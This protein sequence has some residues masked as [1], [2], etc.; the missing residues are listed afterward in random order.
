MKFNTI[1]AGLALTAAICAARADILY[2]QFSV[3][4]Q[5]TFAKQYMNAKSQ[6]GSE[7]LY[8]YLFANGTRSTGTELAAGEG[9]S[10]S[11]GDSPLDY[12]L[13]SDVASA[14][15]YWELVGGTGDAATTYLKSE[16]KSYGDLLDYISSNPTAGQFGV[17]NAGTLSYTLL[18]EPTSGLLLLLGVA[19]LALRRR[20]I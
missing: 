17:F 7:N 6:A 20:R 13:G 9:D 3:D 8:L 16:T 11:S 15:F 4:G 12:V 18:P 10:L 19:G 2:W 5:S 14:S 1:L